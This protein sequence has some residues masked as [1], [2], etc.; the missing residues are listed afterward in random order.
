M[1]LHGSGLLI[2]EY[3]T[4]AQKTAEKAAQQKLEKLEEKR[5]LD[6]SLHALHVRLNE[7]EAKLYGKKGI[8][9]LG[10]GILSGG[11]G[12]RQIPKAADAKE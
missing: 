3:T 12:E 8:W 5:K 1:F 10:L 9:G 2:W 7:I 11:S 4:G 6:E